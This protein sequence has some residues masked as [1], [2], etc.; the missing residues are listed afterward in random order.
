MRKNLL[1]GLSEEQIEKARACKSSEELLKLAKKEGVQL[2][3]EQ[4]AAVSGG[5]CFKA[6]EP[7]HAVCP[8]CGCPSCT[9]DDYDISDKSTRA[10]C[11]N[12]GLEF[13]V[14]VR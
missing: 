9:L 11:P 7:V 14:L 13:D 10:H 4:L 8:Q 12:C 5:A 6:K 1:K 3:D 2:T